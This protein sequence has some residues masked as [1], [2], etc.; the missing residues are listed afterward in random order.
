MDKFTTEELLMIASLTEGRILKIDKDALRMSEEQ[1][2][3]SPQL[4]KEVVGYWRT[5]NGYWAKQTIPKC[6]CDK[7]EGGF[8]AKPQWNGYFYAGEPCSIKLYEKFKEEKNAV[9]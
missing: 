2:M 6:T 8:L 9:K 7:Y 1:L 4:E 5:L 3:W